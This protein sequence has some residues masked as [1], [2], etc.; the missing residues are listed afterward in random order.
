MKGKKHTE[1]SRKKISNSRQ[2][3]PIHEV[4]HTLEGLERIRI[5]MK[6]RII[7]KETKQKMSQSRLGKSTANK[8]IPHSEEA[9]EKMR[10][11]K[12]GKYKGENNPMFGRSPYDIWVEKYG[13]KEANRKK[14]EF[15]KNRKKK[16]AK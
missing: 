1:E 9:K 8:G 11:A 3:N 14:E 4:N 16:N 5:A 13:G 7:S 6:N 10:E 12:L 15:Y 2:K